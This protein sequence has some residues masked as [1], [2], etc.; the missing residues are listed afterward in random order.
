[1]AKKKEPEN[2]TMTQEQ[3]DYIKGYGDK[4]KDIQSFIE[5]V[6]RL[7]GFYIGSKSNEGWLA[8]IREIFQNAFDESMRPLSP[9]SHIRLIFNEANQS[10]T[11]E[12]NGSGIPHG[13]IIHIFTTER[14]SS[15]YEKEK[16]EYTSGAHG[17]GS[18]VA[19]A[20][21]SHFE[22]T[23]YVLGEAIHVEFNEGNPWAKG[24][25]KVVCPP[26]RQGTTVTMLPDLN[27]LGSVNLTCAE[28]YNLVVKILPI[29]KIGMKID[30]VGYDVNGKVAIDQKLVNDA[31]PITGLNMITASPL[32]TPVGFSADTGD[33]KADIFFTYDASDLEDMNILSFGNFTPTTDGT[34][35]SGF[36]NGICKWFRKYMNTFYL[37]KNSKLTI[38][39]VDIKTG[40][41]AV[42]SAACTFPVFKGQFK[43][44]LSNEELEPFVD[45]LTYQS[46][47]NWAKTNPNDLQ[48][49]CKFIKDIAEIRTKSDD[50]RIKLSN[51]YDRDVITGKPKKFV[52]PSGKKGLELFIVEGDSAMGSAKSGGRDPKTQGI[53]PIRGK[54]LNA[55]NTPRAKFLQNPEVAAIIRLVGDGSYGKNLDIN[56]V[57]WDKIII[58]TDAD[59]DGSHINTLLLRLFLM[60]MPQVI[61]AGKLYNAVPPLFAIEKGKRNMKYFSNIADLAQYCQGLFVKKYTLSTLD[62]KPITQKEIIKIFYNNMDYARDMKILSDTLATNIR[63]LETVLFEIARVIDYN[64]S[65]E[66]SMAMAQAASTGVVDENSVTTIVEGS[67]TKAIKY[68]IANLDFKKFKKYMEKTYGFVKVHKENGVIVVEGLVDGKYQHL[69]ISDHTI[70]LSLKMIKQIAANDICKFKLNGE[71]TTLYGVISALDSIKP[72]EIK[73]YKGLG[74]QD[75]WQLKESTMDPAKRTLVRYTVESVKKEIETIRYIDS[76]KSSLLNGITVTRQD[77]E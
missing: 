55:F 75:P 52:E 30:F 62:N 28:I 64:V 36:I 32:I 48:K 3:I 40:L 56:K 72:S 25:Q 71:P 68:S 69:F 13:K 19:L 66:V 77:I 65:G 41:R 59:P 35:V 33:M 27:I 26:N 63:L 39:N 61:E 4:I 1:M 49:V 51:Q 70:Q 5:G 53:F 11:I 43:G 29:S 24:E 58:M 38:V 20:L 2:T 54:L 47:D 8:C 42:V 67:I 22:I 73:R 15:N 76:N 16:G 74:E 14:S 50:S 7:P 45:K 6:R 34:H 46:L 57:K 23:S 17:V 10:A 21:S 18:G 37:P 9:C 31:G 60:Y 44:I 12:D